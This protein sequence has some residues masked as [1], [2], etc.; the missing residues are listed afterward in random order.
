MGIFTEELE[1][2]QPKTGRRPRLQSDPRLRMPMTS[3]VKR[4]ASQKRRDQQIFR[5]VKDILITGE[6]VTP[7][8]LDP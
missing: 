1:R 4:S 2:L 7:E 3:L 5:T 8:S 6:A